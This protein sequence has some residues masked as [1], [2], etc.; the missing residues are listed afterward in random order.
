MSNNIDILTLHNNILKI[1][2]E[3]KDN[4]K[5]YK[6]KYEKLLKLLDENLPDTTKKKIRSQVNSLEKF[7]DDISNNKS[8]NYY[9]MESFEIINKY[10]NNINKPITVNFMNN[11]STS[12]NNL[13]NKQLIK[14]YIHIY[15]K[16][17]TK[18]NYNHIKRCIK[19]DNDS[20]DTIDNNM[21]CNNCGLSIN[22]LIQNSSFK[23]SE[24][25]NIIPK[26]TYNRKTHFK[27]CINQF[28]GKQQVNI[29]QHVYDDLIKQFELNHLLVG[30]EN[31]PKYTRFSNITKK[32]IH[33]FLKETKNSKHYEDINLIY[34]NITG[35]QTNDISHLERRLIQDFDLLTQTY[36]KLFKNNKDI[37]RKSFINSQY[38]LYQ[39]LSR[40]K[41]NC[42]K[43]EFNILKTTDRQTFH[44]DVCK[45]LFKHLG[46]NFKCLF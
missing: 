44:D 41:Y 25:I 42:N 37:E 38:V 40:H 15:N 8:M 22:T 7:I 32:H 30:G 11:T 23:D 5:I 12:I 1:Y 17:N 26:Y 45:E 2:N 27:D 34:H 21:I 33:L 31:I 4:L 10:T 6:K 36:D 46:W 14:D 28:Q 35:K 19:C 18:I 29:K 16:Y 39:L 20:F 43:E 9:I 13:Q 24:R 3:Y